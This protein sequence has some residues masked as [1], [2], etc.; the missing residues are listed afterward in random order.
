MFMLY[1]E[2]K[3]LCENSK[4]VMSDLFTILISY[5][6]KFIWHLMLWSVRAVKTL[7]YY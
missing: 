7:Q 5:T 2:E 4:A 6:V 1:T 3:G